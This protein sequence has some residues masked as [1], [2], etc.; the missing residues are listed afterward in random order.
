M[1]DSPSMVSIFL[2]LACPASIKHALTAIPSTSTVQVPQSPTSQP[3]LAP[4]R[5]KSSRSILSSVV[6]GGTLAVRSSPFTVSV[7]SVISLFPLSVGQV[8]HCLQSSPGANFDETIAVFF[9]SAEI[10]D[11]L[12]F[13]NREFGCFINKL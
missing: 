2:P 4:V 7:T 12:R 6:S 10:I 8:E 11:W 9:G 5:F 13:T 1:V 3:S